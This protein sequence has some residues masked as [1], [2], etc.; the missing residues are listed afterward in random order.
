MLDFISNKLSER[1]LQVNAL[2]PTIKKIND[3]FLAVAQMHNFK[4]A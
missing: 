2:N 3:E 1:K 4:Y